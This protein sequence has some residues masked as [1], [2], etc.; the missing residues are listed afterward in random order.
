MSHIQVEELIGIVD[1]KEVELV[2]LTADLEE[3]SHF[4][5]TRT[6]STCILLLLLPLILLS[7]FL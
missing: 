4:L 6:C 3:V 5:V 7:R 1:E 2:S